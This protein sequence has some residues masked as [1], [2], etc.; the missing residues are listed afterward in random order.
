MLEQKMMQLTAAQDQAWAR[1]SD[2]LTL[3]MQAMAD[4]DGTKDPAVM[5][6]R[7]AALTAIAEV[8]NRRVLAI[9]DGNKDAEASS[10]EQ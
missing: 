2:N 5:A 9:M 8:I 3:I 1:V 6:L 10:E 7:V 4:T